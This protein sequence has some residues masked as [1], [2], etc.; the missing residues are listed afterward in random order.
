M[1]SVL[2]HQVRRA[3]GSMLDLRELEGRV[4][5]IV[6]TASRC[7]FA[8]QLRGLQVLHEQYAKTGLTILAFPCN[9]FRDQEPGSDQ[10]IQSVCATQ[11]GTGFPVLAKTE[12]NGE[13]AL[14]LFKDLTAALPGLLGQR[15]IRWNFTKF[16]VDRQGRPVRR[17]GPVTPCRLLRR[18]IETLL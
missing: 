5:L 18:P 16:L 11:F 2:D 14:P 7:M 4:L 12:V 6:N 17:F 8:D 15:R 9:Q 3:D 1:R 10:E 13:G